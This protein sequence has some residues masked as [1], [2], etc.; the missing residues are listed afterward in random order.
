MNEWKDRETN[1]VK[2]TDNGEVGL[3]GAGILTGRNIRRRRLGAGS[4]W[5]KVRF[6][7]GV[8]IECPDNAT[9]QHKTKDRS[10]TRSL[11]KDAAK[12]AL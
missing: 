1:C 11:T 5:R 2:V 3:V 7:F 12:D 4:W 10:S 9:R 8:I 6:R